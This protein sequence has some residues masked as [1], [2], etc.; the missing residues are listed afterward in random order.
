M[1]GVIA[2]CTLA[3]LL[4]SAWADPIPN[5]NHNHNHNHDHSGEPSAEGQ[6]CRKLSPANADFGFAL[7]K[8]LNAEAGAG[9]NVFFSPLGITS[10]LAMLTKGAGGETYSQLV[11]AL[12][13]SGYKQSQI[14]E[15]YQHLFAM[16]RP[17]ERNQDVFIGN[18]AAVRKG[19]SPLPGYL[20]S[21]S[22]H[23]S[24]KV[25][26]VNFSVP[27]EAV[28]EIN[29]YIALNTHD[30]IKDQVKDLDPDTAMVLINYIY[31]KGR[32]HKENRLPNIHFT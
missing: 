11:S 16:L 29:R 14:D 18:A 26:D 20:N 9:K 1:R 7:Y 24:G 19:F 3:L 31:F 10:A 23:Y 32:T 17:S 4:V 25:F 15:A 12:G 2:S 30:L 28:A 8:S 6:S 13:Y 5:H 27:A 21:V 22:H